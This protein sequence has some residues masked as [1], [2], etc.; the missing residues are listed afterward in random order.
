VNRSVAGPAVDV[1]DRAVVINYGE[2]FDRYRVT[3]RAVGGG[4][5]RLRLVAARLQQ[6]K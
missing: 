4:K 2:L 6:S 3:P 5:K 1:G